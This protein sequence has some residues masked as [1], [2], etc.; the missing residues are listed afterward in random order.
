MPLALA[1]C[2]GY[3]ELVAASLRARWPH[4]LLDDAHALSPLLLRSV[5]ASCPS[6]HTYP[7]HMQHINRSPLAFHPH[8]RRL[9][10]AVVGPAS[11]IKGESTLLATADPYQ[12]PGLSL[13]LP[14]PPPCSCHSGCP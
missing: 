4:V 10:R 5:R 12:A 6:L 7:T 11:G 2:E 1:L 8:A 14:L 3:P 13:S 9:V